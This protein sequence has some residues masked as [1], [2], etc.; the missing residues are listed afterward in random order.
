MEKSRQMYLIY[1][2]FLGGVGLGNFEDRLM[3]V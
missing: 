2:I 1:F 3:S